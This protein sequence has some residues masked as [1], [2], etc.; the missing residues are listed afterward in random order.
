VIS[1]LARSNQTGQLGDRPFCQ[2]QFGE[3]HTH[4]SPHRVGQSKISA[5]RG[6]PFRF[7]LS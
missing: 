7:D 3:H 1:I 5:H 4:V 2:R 6:S